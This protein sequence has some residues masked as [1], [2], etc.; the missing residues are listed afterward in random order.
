M[1]DRLLLPGSLSKSENKYGLLHR[2]HLSL[3]LTNSA[4][5]ARERLLTAVTT[6]WQRPSAC[7][8]ICCCCWLFYYS[9]CPLSD[10]VAGLQ[11]M[12]QYILLLPSHQ[13]QLGLLFIWTLED[14][15]TIC[16]DWDIISCKLILWGFILFWHTLFPPQCVRIARKLS[17]C[18]KNTSI[19]DKTTKD[20]HGLDMN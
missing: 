12:I 16:Q 14:Y 20:K 9:P 13:S 7:S 18:V 1:E 15:V 5:G 17:S 11:S 2:M 6:G 3:I 8:F 19:W 4:N 10:D